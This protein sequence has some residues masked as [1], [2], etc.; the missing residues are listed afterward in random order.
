MRFSFLWL[1]VA[2]AFAVAAVLMWFFL[3]N[4]IPRPVRVRK[5]AAAAGQGTP[6]D[7]AMLK[8]IYLQRMELTEKALQ[9]GQITI[10]EAYQ[11]MSADM[12]DFVK[13]ATGVPVR[14]MTLAEISELKI[15]SLTELV[16]DYYEPEF[17]YY[18]EAD[19]HKSFERTRYVIRKWA[20]TWMAGHKEKQER[21][22]SRGSKKK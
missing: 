14:E 19:A 7:L 3:R 6:E 15:P 20:R 13:R 10:R 16:R 8:Q 4:R 12:R 21:E 17:A 1:I 11:R 22:K 2:A 18:T 9:D 5:P